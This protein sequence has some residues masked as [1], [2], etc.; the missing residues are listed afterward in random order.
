MHADDRMEQPIVTQGWLARR[1]EVTPMTARRALHALM[2]LGIVKESTGYKRNQRFAY[3]EY[4]ALFDD[5]PE[6]VQ[7]T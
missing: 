3:P 4:L 1:L 7:P 6:S 2:D 5:S